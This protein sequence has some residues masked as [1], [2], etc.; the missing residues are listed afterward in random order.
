MKKA[1][2]LKGK[3]D[4]IFS[5]FIRM[6]DANDD[7]NIV[8]PTCNTMH[9]YKK[10]DAGHYITRGDNAVRWDEQN[11]HAQCKRCN[12]R[13]G[14]QHLMGL[15]IDKKYG[16]GT[17]DMLQIKRH[18]TFHTNKVVLKSLIDEYKLKVKKLESKFR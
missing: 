18:N 11:V 1:K 7:G 3:L 5:L 12:L 6:R 17:T 4:D 16:N 10:V 15:F 14:E 9:H 2:G 13:G 8:C